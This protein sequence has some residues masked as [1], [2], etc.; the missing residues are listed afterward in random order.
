MIEP[1]Y[2]GRLLQGSAASSGYDLHGTRAPETFEQH[3]PGHHGW[4]EPI[5]SATR[6]QWRSAAQ[7][8]D[9]ADGTARD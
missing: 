5:D 3:D 4:G 2:V 1:A 8:C 6:N 9:A 7:P